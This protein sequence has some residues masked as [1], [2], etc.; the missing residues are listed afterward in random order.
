[1]TFVA[2]IELTP[3]FRE[4][5]TETL[6]FSTATTNAEP[7]HVLN[8]FLSRCLVGPRA[9][10]LASALIAR[11]SSSW[12]TAEESLRQMLA[13][14]EI[15]FKV[16][17]DSADLDAARQLLRQ[18]LASDNAVFASLQSYQVA[19]PAFITNDRT[20]GAM[21]LLCA[22]L[23]LNHASG[24]DALL[25]L[26]K[27]LCET[28]P[29]PYWVLQSALAGPIDAG[30]FIISEVGPV[31]WVTNDVTRTFANDLGNLLRRAVQLGS[32]AAD[33]LDA[34]KVLANA[35]EFA[36]VLS[37]AQVPSLLT[38]GSLTPL[39]AV[40]S[41]DADTVLDSSA[42]GSLPLMHTAMD[43][44]IA[45]KLQ[46]TVRERLR[47]A[48]QDKNV[49]EEF[50]LQT[51][52][53]SAGAKEK[54]LER[55]RLLVAKTPEALEYLIPKAG[56]AQGPQDLTGPVALVLLDLLKTTMAQSYSQWF[57]H[58]ARRCGF[59]APRRGNTSKRFCIE[60]N[61]IT[62]LVLAALTEEESEISY[63]EFLRRLESRFGI[64][65]GPTEQ[66]RSMTPRASESELELNRDS[67]AD[68]LTR[69]GLARAYSDNTTEVL[70]P[71]KIWNAR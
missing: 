16:P 44:W 53:F 34:L 63:D 4:N 45:S 14:A 27:R 1:M 67:L 60:A 15:P 2:G 9:P 13:R 19:H 59:L 48:V 54:R 49:A 43:N 28:Q 38:T 10:K 47:D 26:V 56:M 61:L 12:V 33:S 8:G 21:G 25:A 20:G 24:A 11:K 64:S 41:P 30:S 51:T 35:I 70:N 46:S 52:P 71:L 68:M 66:T 65:V 17:S 22:S 7:V 58:H 36:C 31:P 50:L 6:V 23:L 5:V 32:V 69:L 62:T 18:L 55:S 3:W 40:V 42:R 37:Y 57:E 29:N 39:L